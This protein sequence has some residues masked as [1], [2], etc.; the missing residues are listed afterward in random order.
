MRFVSSHASLTALLSGLGKTIEALAGAVLRNFKEGSK[1]KPTLIITPQDGVQQQ[2]VES[3]VKAGV[4]PARIRVIG[5][6]RRD[7][8]ADI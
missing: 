6:K 1:R 5:E 7:K 4:E 2:W 3:L 8:S